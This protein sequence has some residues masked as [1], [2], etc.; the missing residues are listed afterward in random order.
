VGPDGQPTKERLP[1]GEGVAWSIQ[2]DD[3]MPIL[4]DAGITPAIA[5]ACGSTSDAG[6]SSNGP[7]NNGPGN[8]SPEAR[9]ASRLLLWAVAALVVMGLVVGF[10]V[11]MTSRPGTARVAG[12]KVGQ[13]GQIP[14]PPGLIPAAE[15]RLRGLS[16][17]YAGKEFPLSA[18]PIT[19]GRDP[20]MSQIVF[21]AQD[22]VVSKRHCT[23][24][25]DRAAGGMVVEDCGSTNGTYLENGERLRAGEPRLV[26]P[27]GS[28]YLGDRRHSF[29]VKG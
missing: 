14:M 22:S 7:T 24:R 1:Y 8:S 28:F 18:E 16:G 26:R 27:Y 9:S 6:T 23:V 17:P 11:R 5:N 12:G 10:V 15:F 4:H 13:A 21:D 3:L 29:Q 2:A 25:I 20:H 19:L